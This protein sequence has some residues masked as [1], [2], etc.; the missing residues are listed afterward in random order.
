MAAS[1]YENIA[2]NTLEA[3]RRS[4]ASLTL[5]IT[6]LTKSI[7]IISRDALA[8]QSLCEN[9]ILFDWAAYALY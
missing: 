4:L 9:A 1:I 5:E 3:K 8:N 6:F 2:F 7:S